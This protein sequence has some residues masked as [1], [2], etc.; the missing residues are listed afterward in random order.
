MTLLRV[1]LLTLLLAG[2]TLA[3]SSSDRLR[4]QQVVGGLSN[5]VG[6]TNA[7]DGSSRLF[8]TLQNGRIVIV[9]NGQLRS[10]PFLDVSALVSCCGE[11]GLLGV[12][13]HPSYET[14]GIFF[15]NYTDRSGDTV[16]ARYRVRTGDPNVAEPSS[17]SVLLRVDQPFV[18]H[19]GGDIRFGPDGYLYLALGD[20]GSGGDPGNRAQNLNE[21]L[22]KI[23]RIDV[24]SGTPYGIPPTNPFL[25]RSGARP[26]IWA[27]GVRNPWRTSFDKLT[28]DYWIGDVGQGAL[29]EIDFQPATSAG[30]ENYGWRRM[31][32]TRCFNPGSNCNDGTLTLPVYEY[33]RS[34]G[35]SVTGGY[36]YRGA[37]YPG[38]A[39]TYLFADFATGVVFGTTRNGNS[40]STNLLAD[41]PYLIS[42]FG[43]GED[44]ELYLLDYKP[45]GGALFRIEDRSVPRRRTTRR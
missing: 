27:L 43:E 21:L 33:G 37:R 30:G 15:I 29:E 41:S 18:N 42:S 35:V 44:G 25:G 5:P 23:L 14:N 3:Q 40:F 20:G 32:G 36:V 38:L 13:F 45:T 28:G 22:G 7:G 34:V 24:D 31:E 39:G 6:I 11:Q 8:I 16:V 12:A 19:N 2:T 4:F 1:S 26:E 17:A 10:T 9:Q